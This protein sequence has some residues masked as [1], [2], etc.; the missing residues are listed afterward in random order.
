[1][2]RRGHCV[3]KYVDDFVGVGT[4]SIA[5]ASYDCPLDLLRRLGLDISKKK[6]CPPSA[7]AVCLGIEID[8]VTRTISVPQEKLQ[9]IR[10]MVD[11]WG[12]RRFC[13]VRQLQ[14]LLGHLMYIPKSIKLSRYFVNRI[15][16]LLRSN[17]DARSITLTQDFKR[18][19]RWFQKF[20]LQYNGSSFYDHKPVQAVLELDACL[21]GL[22]SCLA[23][24]M[25]KYTTFQ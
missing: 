10:H 14:S 2:R 1:M 21:V 17:Y 6:L 18:D 13:S 24:A 5:S 3:I 16:E 23:G 12:N 8:T 11:A 20:L 7:K 25:K 19:I 9:R 4:P 22:V 15:L